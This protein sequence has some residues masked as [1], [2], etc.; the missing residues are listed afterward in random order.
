MHPIIPHLGLKG[1]LH[2]GDLQDRYRQDSPQ[3]R[4]EE[5]PGPA[6]HAEPGGDPDGARRGQPPHVAIDIV[7]ALSSA[8]ALLCRRRDDLEGALATP[9]VW[10][11]G[12]E[13]YV[14]RRGARAE[15]FATIRRAYHARHAGR[16]S[17][18]TKRALEKQSA[19]Q[20]YRD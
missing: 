13:R 3:R 11:V 4:R 2:S 18:V 12:G 6:S 5:Q 17:R 7:R 14:Y 8:E 20:F 19:F 9:G 1:L 10:G 15:N 16:R